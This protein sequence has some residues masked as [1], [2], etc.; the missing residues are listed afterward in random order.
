MLW[1]QEAKHEEDHLATEMVDQDL[2]QKG[3][4]KDE[5]VTELMKDD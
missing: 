4:T 5:L 3:N 1:I 2:N